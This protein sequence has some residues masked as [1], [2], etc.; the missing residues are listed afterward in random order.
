MMGEILVPEWASVTPGGGQDVRI[1]HGKAV[2][3][4]VPPPSLL[5]A[6]VM[7]LHCCVHSSRLSVSNGDLYINQPEDQWLSRN[8]SG[9]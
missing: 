1:P 7:L 2:A 5:M 8:P 4:C 9:L 3:L 6:A